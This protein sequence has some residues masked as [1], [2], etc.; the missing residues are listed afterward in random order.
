MK[1]DKIH[2]SK[3]Q[4]AIDY[5]K[6]IKKTFDPKGILNPYKVSKEER[7]EATWILKRHFEL[8]FTSLFIIYCLSSTLNL[9]RSLFFLC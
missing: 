5:M 6:M 8:T 4:V 7:A 2:Y 9:H 1:A 3:P